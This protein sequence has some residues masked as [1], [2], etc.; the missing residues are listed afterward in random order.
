MDDL[1]WLAIYSFIYSF[2]LYIG[3]YKSM[4]DD[5]TA[6]LTNLAAGVVSAS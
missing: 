3:T 4:H 5:V 1:Q 2:V 6:G